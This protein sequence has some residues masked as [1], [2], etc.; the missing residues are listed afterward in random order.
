MSVDG[1]D[2]VTF[3]NRF[4]PEP[5]GHAVTVQGL[6]VDCTGDDDGA[7]AIIEPL[8]SDSADLSVAQLAEAVRD[9][10]TS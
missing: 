10:S 5:G 1:V 9:V 7:T 2:L 4:D 6:V 8:P 3:T